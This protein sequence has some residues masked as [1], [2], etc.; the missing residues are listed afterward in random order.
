MRSFLLKAKTTQPIKSVH[1][2]N[3]HQ[4]AI[5]V[6]IAI[7][8]QPSGW[9]KFAALFG[10]HQ[11]RTASIA[12]GLTVAA[13]ISSLPENCLD[14]LASVPVTNKQSA[15]D[16][17]STR[18][19]TQIDP[20]ADQ[21]QGEISAMR[22]LHAPDRSTGKLIA[23]TV[24]AV[25][26]PRSVANRTASGNLQ[27][28]GS[29]ASVLIDVPTPRS[30][31]FKFVPSSQQA[32]NPNVVG[33][34]EVYHDNTPIHKTGVTNIG[35]NWP[36]AGTLTSRYG[37]RW[38]RMH[39]GID[40]AGPIGTPIHAAADGVTIASGWSSGGYGN[41]VEIRHSDGTITRYAHNRR[42]MVAVGQIVHQGQQIAEMGSTGHSTGSHVHFEIRPS[43]GNA[44][45]PIGH[46]PTNTASISRL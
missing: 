13:G 33:S 26:Y 6:P 14:A 22:A 35:F 25:S 37:R 1:S 7:P 30:R 20:Y 34:D 38:G 23:Q 12:L 40:I 19:T 27:F 2:L 42:L 39:K 28:G 17:Q 11:S 31:T 44:V 5:A 9:A 43:G 36:A 10:N 16:V 15:L 41:L 3:T 4:N 46:L 45:N 8:G 18:S 32:Y 29:E 21:L 24:P